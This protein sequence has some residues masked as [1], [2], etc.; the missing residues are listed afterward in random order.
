MKYYLITGEVSGD[1]HTAR[2]MQALQVQDKT[3][4]FRYIGGVNMQAVAP[5]GLFMD[6][7]KLSV[8]GAWEVLK[9]IWTLKTYIKQTCAD[10]LKFKPDCVIL[11]DF[12]GFNLRVAK[13]AKR[14]HIKVI[15]YIS[16]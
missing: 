12:A 9:K 11:V 7:K 4:R 2:L 15:Y 16:A 6:I 13:F 14:H 1:L 8:M 10:I 5:A 3:A